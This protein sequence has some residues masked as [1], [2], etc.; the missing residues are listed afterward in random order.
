[1][2]GNVVNYQQRSIY[3][4]SN[5]N[6][7]VFT[8]NPTV[9]VAKLANTLVQVFGVSSNNQLFVR[10]IISTNYS[11]QGGNFCSNGSRL[12]TVSE[13]MAVVYAR[14]TSTLNYS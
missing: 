14:N 7:Y 12:L 4:T 10:Q 13:T 1:M 11:S 6:R 9:M 2:Q 8:M 5:Y 3:A